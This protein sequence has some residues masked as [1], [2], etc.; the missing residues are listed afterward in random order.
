[1]RQS[2]RY[3]ETKKLIDKDKL[4][5]MKEAIEILKSA[6]PVK[7]DQTLE[8]SCKLSVDPKQSEQMVRG[9]VVLSHGTGKK[10]KILVFCEPEKEQEAVNS[11]ADYAG[12]QE[13]IDKISKENWLDFDCCI[14]TPSMMKFVSKLGKILGPRGLM[15]SPK[16]QTVTEN[17][18][19]AIK[20]VK[21]GKIDF[22][23]DKLGCIHIGLGKISMSSQALSENVR[24]FLDA[25]IN[26]KP[27][28]VKGDFIK[29]VCLSATMSPS[30][31]VQL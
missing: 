21:Q 8:L 17:I 6:P 4:Y 13:L 27:A 24:V 20:E 31:R 7:F 23:M 25:L 29:S 14:A 12:S 15:P 1:M 9:S 11:G 10:I 26:S 18:S 2:R 22:R 3:L 16:T 28:A 5:S 30:L 19:Y